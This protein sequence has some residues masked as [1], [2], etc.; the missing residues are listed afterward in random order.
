MIGDLVMENKV[1]SSAALMC[2]ILLASSFDGFASLV[3]VCVA[4]AAAAIILAMI[5]LAS[6]IQIRRG[7]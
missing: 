3:V 1:L 7:R 6:E 4:I 2:V 5:E